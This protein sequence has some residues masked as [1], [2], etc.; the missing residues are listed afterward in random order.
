MDFSLVTG[1]AVGAVAGAG[2]VVPLWLAARKQAEM[3]KISAETLQSEQQELLAR[4]VEAETTQDM[5]SQRV[6]D[7]EGAM[8]QAEAARSQLAAESAQHAQRAAL[9]EQQAQH[10]KREAEQRIKDWQAA[11]EQ[12]IQAARAAVLKAGTDLSSKLLEDHK[13][14]AEVARKANEE[15]VETK[16]KQFMEQLGEMQ[17]TIAVLHSQTEDTAKRTYGMWQA[18]SSPGGAGRLSEIGLANL[19]KNLG[20]TEGQDYDLQFS[21]NANATDDDRGIRPDALIYL[22]QDAVMIIDSKASKH[23]LEFG[24]HATGSDEEAAARA[25]LRTSMQ[26]HLK[27]LG[28]KDYRAK[29]EQHFRKTKGANALSQSYLVMYLPAESM[30]Q[31]LVEVEPNFI[32]QAKQQYDIFVTGPN[33]LYGLL[34]LAS[35]HIKIQRQADGQTRILQQVEEMVAGAH[36]AFA[37]VE[38]I[39]RGLKG[40]ADGLSSF[41]ASL[42]RFFLPKAHGLARLGVNV[43][44]KFPARL[45]SVDVRL[46]EDTLT[47]EGELADMDDAETDAPAPLRVASSN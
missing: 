28:G 4:A 15:I 7:A 42:N 14:E 30:L 5:L 44:P 41:T 22:P 39:T 43:P 8:K 16:S 33:G 3:A 26:T 13:R 11:Q 38:K 2:A 17:K 37:H 27:S 35:G 36:K 1:L 31:H 34:G 45:N 46:Q 40:A 12:A 25:K 20:L 29:I 32:A 47:I 24:E 18:L 21:I 19:L 23:L 9:A 6:A 10:A